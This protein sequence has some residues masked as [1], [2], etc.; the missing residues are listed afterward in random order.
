[1]GLE[2]A[3]PQAATSVALIGVQ[4]FGRSYLRILHELENTGQIRFV[5]G[6]DLMPE[7][8]GELPGHASFHSDHREMLAEREPDVTIV[9][10]PPH[11]HF[12][13]ARDAI[14][15]GS[16]VLLEKPPVVSI[17][18]HLDLME[19]CRR[20]GRICQ[21]GFQGLASAAIQRLLEVAAADRL[22]EITDI[23]VT[24]RWI[25][26]DRYYERSAW[27]GRRERDGVVVADGVATNPLAHPVMNALRIAQAEDPH[28]QPVQLDVEAYRCRDIATDDTASIRLHMSN[29]KHVHVAVT[30]CAETLA[31]PRVIVRGTTTDAVLAD[32]A[33][34]V[35]VGGI[36]E[37]VPA[38][39]GQPLHNLLSHR[40]DPARVTLL[41]PLGQTLAFTAFLE[42]M[43]NSGPPHR[44]APEFLDERDEE[45]SRRVILR[46]IDAVIAEAGRRPALFSEVG[47]PWA[48][49]PVSVPLATS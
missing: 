38:E 4:G 25:R 46:G 8:S 10:T 31:D 13:I 1:M 45:G 12:Q 20:R 9:A 30:L 22:G 39:R 28:A 21:V 32:T 41:A 37:H 36:R 42:G 6:S 18:Q 3:F 48:V 19:L 40:R 14:E 27:A 15:A 7:A 26:L 43:M 23:S 16:D 33:T 35:Y 34:S 2:T 5:A 49:P 47:T 44:L 24:A 17:G 29:G 11:T